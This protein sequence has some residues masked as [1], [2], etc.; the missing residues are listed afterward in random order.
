MVTAFFR[1]TFAAAGHFQEVMM[2]R[3]L[4]LKHSAGWSP[5]VCLVGVR[6]V[7][8]I[9]HML[10]LL[11]LP[12]LGDFHAVLNEAIWVDVACSRRLQ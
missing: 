4:A 5:F 8:T 3:L 11:R 7:C 9:C 10:R 6:I 1:G 12:V 2:D